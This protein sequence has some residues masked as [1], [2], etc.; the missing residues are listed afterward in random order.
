MNDLDAFNL[1][2]RELY[3]MATE[4]AA[5]GLGIS[6]RTDF[7]IFTRTAEEIKENPLI[8]KPR[9]LYKLSRYKNKMHGDVWVAHVSNPNPRREIAKRLFFEGFIISKIENEL[10]IIGKMIIN[11]NRLTTA[12]N[13]WKGNVYNP[14]DLDMNKL[15]EFISLERYFG[16][17]KRDDFSLVEYFKDK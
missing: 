14:S 3:E 17:G 7:G 9:H 13:G 12:V 15:G 11:S 1:S 16:P 10:K 4:R 5:K 2:V 6:E 8:N